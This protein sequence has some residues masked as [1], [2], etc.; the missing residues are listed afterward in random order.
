MSPLTSAPRT[1]L[2][3]LMQCSWCRA[4]MWCLGW[5]GWQWSFSWCTCA[6]KCL[7]SHDT[8]LPLSCIALNPFPLISLAIC[9]YFWVTRWL[10]RERSKSLCA[11]YAC[12][13]PSVICIPLEMTVVVLVFTWDLVSVNIPSSYLQCR[14]NSQMSFFPTLKDAWFGLW[15]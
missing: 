7:L 3:P 14:D 10:N 4:E 12:S 15:S 2:D 5:L 8:W 11:H 9:K 6:P 1:M 13:I